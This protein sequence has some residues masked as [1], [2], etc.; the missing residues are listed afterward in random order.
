MRFGWVLALALVGCAVSAEKIGTTSARLEFADTNPIGTVYVRG[1]G[2]IDVEDDY[3]PHVVCCENGAAHEEALK[4]QAVMA[5]TYMYFKYFGENLGTSGNPLSGTPSDQAYFC[6]NS[7]SSACRAAVD[8]TRGQVT[9]FENEG[10]TMSNVSFFIDGPRPSCL[11]DRSCTCAKPSPT[12]TMTPNDHATCDCLEF[13]SQG[14]ANPAFLTYN[15]S[16][17]GDDVKG[18]TLGNPSHESNRGC[19]SQNIQS[20]LGYAGWS[21][22]DMLRFFYGQDIEIR[23]TSGAIVEGPGTSS[24][25]AADGCNASGHASPSSGPWPLALLVLLALRGRSARSCPTGSRF[26]LQ[27]RTRPAPCS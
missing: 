23:T 20:C 9:T 6:N 12:T 15:W 7:P 26:R 17:S 1:K 5:R 13:S 24:S 27:R 22:Q 11:S 10:Q 18:S 19:A 3:L 21:Y 16:R 2:A 14:A 4:A 8:A 25:A